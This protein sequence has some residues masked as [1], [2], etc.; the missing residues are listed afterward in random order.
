MRDGSGPSS[1]AGLIRAF[2]HRTALRYDRSASGVAEWHVSAAL[3]QEAGVG[4]EDGVSAAVAL[5]ASHSFE[6]AQR[7]IERAWNRGAAAHAGAA[8]RAPRPFDDTLLIAL[9]SPL[10]LVAWGERR[11]YWLENSASYT[12]YLLSTAQNAALIRRGTG[13]G[14]GGDSARS[15]RSRR[16]AFPPASKRHPQL[17][18]LRYDAADRTSRNLR[19]AGGC[20]RDCISEV[21]FRLDA[22]WYVVV[23]ETSEPGQ[24]TRHAR[25]AGERKK[26]T[27]RRTFPN[28]TGPRGREKRNHSAGKDRHVQE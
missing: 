22:Q 26:K 3:L 11:L 6:D 7:R 24:V 15:R 16:S 23:E 14:S 2:L 19:C 9:E 21:R 1:V 20:E 18:M 25:K 8:G 13:G 5:T 4:E 27:R 28:R 12:A 17:R 10:G